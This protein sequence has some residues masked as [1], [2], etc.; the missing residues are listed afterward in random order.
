[1]DLEPIN[2]VARTRACWESPK[3]KGKL[4]WFPEDVGGFLTEDTLL[5]DTE[6]DLV[7]GHADKS[8]ADRKRAVQ[9]RTGAPG[10]DYPVHVRSRTFLFFATVGGGLYRA[11]TSD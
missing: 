9:E 6:V 7:V 3:R 1:M 5:V 4:T 8:A 2:Q 11:N 10:T